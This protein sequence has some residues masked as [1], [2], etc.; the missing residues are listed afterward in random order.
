[1]VYDS[2]YHLYRAWVAALG[3]ARRRRIRTGDTMTR[4]ELLSRISI[5]PRVCFGKPCIRGL[6]IT[7]QP[8]RLRLTNPSEVFQKLLQ[9]LVEEEQVGAQQLGDVDDERLRLRFGP[10]R[11]WGDDAKLRTPHCGLSLADSHLGG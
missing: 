7:E 3:P 6:R 4:E 11:P 10:G 2:I 8:A 1:M 9:Q 5:D